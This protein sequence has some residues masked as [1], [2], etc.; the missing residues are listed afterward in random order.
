MTEP[1]WG[2]TLDAQCEDKEGALAGFQAFLA[3][4]EMTKEPRYLQWAEHAMD[5]ALTYAVLWDID[6]PPGRLR[7]HGFKTRGWT[8]VSAQ[9]QHLDVFGVLYTPEIWRMGDYLR[10]DDLKRLA[11]VMYRS[12]GQIIDP[13][14]SQGEQ[15]QHTT[16]SR[17]ATC[18]TRREPAAATRSIGRL[19]DHGP[20]SHAARSSRKCASTWTIWRR[21]EKRL[22]SAT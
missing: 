9:N 7:D 14:G 10:R 4:Y 17:R 20:L 12:C 18:P 19:L 16:S 15:I 3:V 8:I 6:M 1:Y 5:V 22:G 2:G 11:A 21:G 13:Y